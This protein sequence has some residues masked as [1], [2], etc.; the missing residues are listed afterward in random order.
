MFVTNLLQTVFKLGK[1]VLVVVGSLDHKSF[2][3][4]PTWFLNIF[5][6][7]HN[8]VA[9]YVCHSYC[10]DNVATNMARKYV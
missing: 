3:Q 5:H 4:L 8:F 6:S 9:W 1:L 2:Q 7:R 10:F